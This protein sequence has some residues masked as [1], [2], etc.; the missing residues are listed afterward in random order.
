MN[1]QNRQRLLV[2]GGTT[3][4]RVWAV[5]GTTVLAETRAMIGARDAARDGNNAAWVRQLGTLIAQAEQ[6]ARRQVTDWHPACVAA[7]GMITSPLGLA[8][9]PHVPAPADVHALAAGAR[10]LS[11]PE[12]TPLPILLVPGVRCGPTMPTAHDI[13]AVDVMR[14][15]EV[16][17]LGLVHSGLLPAGGGMLSVG[18]HWKLVE[19]EGRSIRGSTTTLSGELLHALRT[20]T[21]LA[22]SVDPELPDALTGNDLEAMRVGVRQR[23]MAGFTRAAF[24]T[25]LLERVSDST[26]RARLLFL[27]GVVVAETMAHWRGLLQGRTIA[28]LGAPALCQAWEAALADAGAH[29]LTIAPADV[30]TAYAAGLGAIVEVHQDGT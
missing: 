13:D 18:S 11:M 7:A 24:C 14:G 20:Q 23:E 2:D 29:G 30:T 17:C 8:E 1:T 6:K 19:V 10:S 5:D 4:T 26:P 28:L 25:R 22:A 9:V 12:L 15:E 27:L 16:V 21:V 3:T